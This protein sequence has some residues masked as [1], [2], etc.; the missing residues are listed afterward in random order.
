MYFQTIDMF[1]FSSF[2]IL[3]AAFEKLLFEQSERFNSL[4]R[5]WEEREKVGS[6]CAARMKRERG[7][8]EDLDCCQGGERGKRE[9]GGVHIRLGTERERKKA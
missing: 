6:A 8:G 9:K 5:E 2:F 4:I 3:S 1:G 7:G